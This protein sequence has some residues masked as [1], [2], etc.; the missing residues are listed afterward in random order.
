M[1]YCSDA[2]LFDVTLL[3]FAIVHIIY[4][5]NTFLLLLITVVVNYFCLPVKKKKT[6]PVREDCIILI[7]YA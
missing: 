4:R 2:E 5:L 7:V 6:V 1:L 3:I